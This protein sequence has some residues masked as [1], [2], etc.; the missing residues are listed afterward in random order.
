MRLCTIPAGFCSNALD[1]IEDSLTVIV[2]EHGVRVLLAVESGSRAWGFPSP[3]SDYDCRFFYA[4]PRDNYLSLWQERDVIELPLVGDM[5]INGWDLAKALRLLLKGNA[6]VLEWLTS[7]IIYAGDAAVRDALLSFANVHV[8]RAMVG[9]HY[10]HLGEA[11]RRLYL[12]DPQAVLLK[13]LFYALRP[14]AA[15]RWLRL[16]PE[17]VVAPMDFPSLM[18]ACDPPREVVHIVAD[19]IARKALTRELGSAP[20]PSAILRFIDTEFE[21]AKAEF[22]GVVA[23]ISQAARD[24]ADMLFRF[25]IGQG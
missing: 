18:A 4:R 19:L 23:P 7:P 13:K 6:V 17:Q 5:D 20:V 16:H 14:A 22:D 9:R 15:L 21:K 2:K 11:Q 8:N 3:D 24:D 12:A 25:I 10:L 1:R